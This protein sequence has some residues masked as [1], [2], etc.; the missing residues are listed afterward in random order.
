[1]S[2]PGTPDHPLRVAIIGSGPS[3]FYAAEHLLNRDGLHVQV[4]MFDRLPTPFGLVRGGVAPDHQKI[5]SVTRIYDKIAA[6]PAYRFFGNVEIGRDLARDDLLAYFHAVIYAVGAKADRRMGVPGEYLP[7]S[8]S[9]TDFVGWYNAHP[10]FRNLRFDLSGTR[11][12]VVGNGNVAVDV[13]RILASTPAE[14]ARTDIAEHARAALAESRITEVILMGRRGPA[15]SAFTPKELKEM[16]EMEGAQVIVD[17]ADVVLDDLSAAWVADH[18][19]RNRDTN[20]TVMT[21]YA[22]RPDTGAP[23]RIV[24]RFLSSPTRVLGT[25]RV[26]AVEIVHNQLQPAGDGQLRPRP[27]DRTETIPVD[28]VFRAIGYQGTPLPGLPFDDWAGVIP[29]R[30]GRIINPAADGAVVPAEYVVGWIKRGPT[31][32]IGTNKP[33]AHATVDA[34]LADHAAGTLNVPQIPDAGVLARLVAERQCEAVSYQDWLR[35]DAIERDRGERDGGRP[36]V[37]FS[38]IPEMIQALNEDTAAG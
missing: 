1:M 32:I 36:R 31:G 25:D 16:G 14:L 12:L 37:K 19:D 10:D 34:L 18:P 33:D 29:N 8:H 21:G 17:P 9:A 22:Q 6:H 28:L 38:R 26:E 20:I 24:L 4:D 27:T 30:D 15:Q 7:G 11:A 2:E 23:R 35:L 3:G 13:A 5:K